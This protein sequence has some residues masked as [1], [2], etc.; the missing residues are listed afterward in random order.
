MLFPTIHGRTV[1]LRN[2]SPEEVSIEYVHWLNDP[3]ITK[4][5]EVR[6][7]QVTLDTQKVFIDQINKST[8]TYI[9][10]IFVHG[11]QMVGTTKLGPIDSDS[12]TGDIGILIG[13]SNYW[14][15]GVATEAI[16]ILCDAFK[17]AH[18]LKKVSAGAAETNIGSI[19]AFEN[20]GFSPEE[21]QL[22]SGID[23]YGNSVRNVILTKIL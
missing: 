8:D 22:G 2:I 17:S 4:Y 11:N 10:G 7:T 1:I 3:L 14:Q 15:K 13:D 6:R 19:K 23:E 9:F 18:L 5:L 20:N 21:M 12:R 16:Q